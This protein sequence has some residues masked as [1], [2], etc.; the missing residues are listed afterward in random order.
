MN[1]EN[2]CNNMDIEN[3]IIRTVEQSAGITVITDTTGCIL[4]VNSMF[5]Q[6]TGYEPNEVIGKKPNIM[7]S[8][9]HDSEFYTE[10]WKTVKSGKTWKGR[11]TNKKKDGELFDEDAHIFPVINSNGKISHYAK[12]SFDATERVILENQLIQAQ[13][14]EA[15][16]RLA[17]GI[18]HD[19][20]N[21][22]TGIQGYVELS[23]NVL[24]TGDPL[25]EY[26]EEI[27]KAAQKASELVHQ[28]LAFS[29]KQMVSPKVICINDV[30]MDLERIIRRVIGENIDFTTILSR[31]IA[32]IKMDPGQ[33][34]QIVMNLAVN[35]RDAMTQGGSLTIETGMEYLGENFNKKYN[36]IK[37]GKYVLLAIKDTGVGMDEE[38][39]SHIFE[40]FFTTKEKCKGTGLGLSTVYGIV[41][42]ANGYII[43]YSEPGLGTSFKLYF[44]PTEEKVKKPVLKSKSMTDFRKGTE[45]I[46]VVEDED[47]I[48]KLL[49][50]ILRKAGYQVW[51]AS[52]GSEAAMMFDNLKESVDLLITDMVLPDINGC[53]LAMKLSN[54]H[55][56]LKIL[57]MS[58]YAE[59][60]IAADLTGLES[61]GGFISKPFKPV[62]MLKKIGE[63][64]ESE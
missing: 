35:A 31:D 38:T 36:F 30:V 42:Q 60:E 37:P 12:L 27:S 56:E 14:M 55:K 51:L 24:S 62:E 19:F 32:S 4:Y 52:R 15:I 13:K 61:K 17:G 39:L 44:T 40:P 50:K 26:V 33:L 18:A 48:R 63:L 59:E 49:E 20:N 11:I 10:I 43:V 46:F 2:P 34:G 3:R 25:Y 8:G 7:K 6:I 21:L 64:L 29:R 53:E 28:I 45:N 58:G 54:K 1:H 47:Y 16:G 23:R 5:T 41:K 9:K 22:L 57:F